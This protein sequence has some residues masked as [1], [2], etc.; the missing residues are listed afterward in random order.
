M[1]ISSIA[2]SFHPAS[3]HRTDIN[4]FFRL[5]K[6]LF[7]PANNFYFLAGVLF[8]I[9]GCEIHCLMSPV[10][11]TISIIGLYREPQWATVNSVWLCGCWTVLDAS[12]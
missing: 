8:M 1:G 3:I 5:S 2:T 9:G 4:I 10:S 12:G 11:V 6:I 7:M